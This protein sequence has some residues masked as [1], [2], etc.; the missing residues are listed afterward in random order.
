M[1]TERRSGPRYAGRLL[2]RPQLGGIR[3]RGQRRRQVRKVV[4]HPARRHEQQRRRR[5]TH[6]PED[7]RQVARQEHQRPGPGPE[8]VLATLFVQG[9][10]EDRPVLDPPRSGGSRR[11]GRR[12]PSPLSPWL[13]SDTSA[14]LGRPSRQPPGPG[15]GEP[16]WV[17]I[18]EWRLSCVNQ[19][20]HIRPLFFGSDGD[21]RPRPVVFV[22]PA[23]AEARAGAGEAVGS[24]QQ[25]AILHGLLPL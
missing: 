3:I 13:A 23:L 10:R 1:R 25:Q 11:P 17:D 22:L 2:D 9:P 20:A 15:R 7:V 4:V 24:G 5:T 19:A 12:P 21:Q 18:L 6:R 14:G 16:P 8:P